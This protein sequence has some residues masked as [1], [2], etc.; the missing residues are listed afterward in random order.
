M[1]Q[2][3]Y[4]E[5]SNPSIKIK[6]DPAIVSLLHFEFL[7]EY[8]RFL[9]KERI[10]VLAEEQQR[11]SFK[12]KLPILGLFAHLPED[13]LLERGRQG[14]IKLLEAL[15]ANRV[16]E[17]IENAVLSWVNNKIPN[18]S[19]NQ[20]SSEDISLIGFIRSKLFRDSLPYYT[21]D[22]DLCLLLMEE[23]NAFN[24]TLETLFVRRLIGMQ[25]EL[26]DQAQQ[27]AHIGNWS[28]EITTN[29][30]SW[31]DELFRIYELEP[32]EIIT[33]D[34]ASFNHPEDAD[35]IKDQIRIS[36]ET[37]Q[38]HDFYYRIILKNGREKFLHACGQVIKN[39][40]GE[41]E[42]MY[43]TVQDVSLQKKIE[44]EH[45]DNEHFIQKVTELTPSLISVYNIKTGRYLF[46]NQA[47]QSILGYPAEEVFK[48]GN[49]FFLEIMHPDDL[50]RATSEINQATK[51]QDRNFG[52]SQ[53]EGIRQSRY[54]LR[55]ANGQYR[56]F[57]TFGAVFERNVDDNI[58]TVI[59]VSMDVSEQM[60]SDRRL[61][62]N[63]DE[64]RR[65]EDLYYKMID[66][67]EDYAILLLSPDG[68]IENWN[69][70][71]E[72]IKG[73]KPEEIIGKNFR[74]FYPPQDVENKVPEMLIEEALRNGKASHEG[75]RVRKDQS[76]FWGSIVIT[77]LHNKQGEVIGF[78]KVT[79]DLT[80]RKQAED[81]LKMYA[82]SLEQ[83]N[84]E[85]KLKNQDL[86]S[87]GYI[88]SHDLQEPV[89]KIQIWANRLEE[90]EDNSDIL[91]DT[92]S[93]IQKACVQMQNLI[94]GIL[95]YSH[96]DQQNMPR[97]LTDLDLVLDEAIEGFSDI[98][99]E[100]QIILTK[101]HLPQLPIVRIQ[102]LQL[103]SNILSNAI[104]FRRPGIPLRIR[105]SSQLVKDRLDQNDKWKDFYQITISDNGIGFMQEYADKMFELFRRLESGPHYPGTGIGLAIC[106][107]IVM[108]HN[109]II[110]AT[111]VPGEGASFEILLPA[112]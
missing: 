60:E 78:S 4:S 51:Q 33:Y 23:L 72:K 48:K 82:A 80:Q 56:W 103:F 90:T 84:Q 29:T 6:I 73:Y 11:L 112:G 49:K 59:N 86:E 83:K 42:K 24:S 97:E 15:S 91:K 46:I 99:E 66:E 89:R 74:I 5:L 22:L 44:K 87:F 104:R 41:V 105:I 69:S 17:Y 85:L 16:L 34:L 40:L 12:L 39:R 92:L 79:R 8:C 14:L 27:I 68:I 63:E 64:I 31:S 100:K 75:W 106:K 107:K 88:A 13:Q 101:E 30:I 52:P 47:I 76:R 1:F 25:Q 9:L 55:H 45:R 57:Q 18:L 58:E 26:Y 3:G 81:N 96:T 65:Q 111:G 50:P 71:A 36:R 54:R 61:R 93:R 20:I 35:F 109:G 43:G 62:Q 21:R 53:T 70:G 7:P 38:P 102:F 28:L 2:Q 77:A 10:N 98:I 110:R 67:V 108:N 94:K 32:Q 19:F 95:Q 37:G